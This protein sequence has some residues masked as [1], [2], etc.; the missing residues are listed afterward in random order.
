L[1][2]KRT[3]KGVKDM[4]FAG[5]ILE[6][7]SEVMGNE[8]VKLGAD[9]ALTKADVEKWRTGMLETVTM[10]EDGDFVALK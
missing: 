7:A 5:V 9:D 8:G 2:V 1:E 10:A 6:Y 3:V 4:G